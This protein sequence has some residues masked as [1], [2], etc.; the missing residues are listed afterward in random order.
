MAAPK[1]LTDPARRKLYGPLDKYP[2]G[3]LGVTKF[4]LTTV[5]LPWGMRVTVHRLIAGVLLSACVEA[6]L[7]SRW[8]PRRVDS[9]NPRTIR[10]STAL[11]LHALGLAVDVFA[12]GPGVPPPGGVWT[13]DNGVPA[14]FAE[15]FL[16]RGF[17]WGATWTRRDV[18][19]IEWAGGLP[20]FTSPPR[21]G[22]DGASPAP[23]PVPP[24]ATIEDDVIRQGD[25]GP[26]VAALQR[27]VNGGL[28]RSG[29]TD[30]LLIADG[31]YGPRSAD[32]WNHARLRAQ[33]ALGFD[34]PEG[35]LEPNT[36]TVA[37]VT[38]W[39]A[40]LRPA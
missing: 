25:S 40:S 27:L 8:N 14:D 38:Q 29:W 26:H 20:R 7:V 33:N 22:V 4:N 34:F 5:T 30:Q 1:R 28:G 9:F 39:V 10:G 16:A 24:A 23:P 32:L 15:P 18:P 37:M 3:A 31:K 12:T 11:S 21:P 35:A 2:N 36:V 13:P 6:D 19:H 17:T